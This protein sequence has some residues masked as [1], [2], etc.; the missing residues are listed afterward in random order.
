MVDA[1][2]TTQMKLITVEGEARSGKGTATRAIVEVL[3]LAGHKVRVVDQGQKFRALAVCAI[4]SGVDTE[5]GT[6]LQQFLA[7]KDTLPRMLSLLD[8]LHGVSDAERDAVLYTQEIGTASSMVGAQAVSQQLAIDLL[9][10][11]V[12]KAIR[13][14]VE[15]LVIDG[16]AMSQ[17]A[18]HFEQTLPVTLAL[19]L[20]FRTWA[21]VAARR[22]TGIMTPEVELVEKE[23]ESLRIAAEEVTKRNE[24]DRNRAV[25][26]LIDPGNAVRIDL[27]RVQDGIPGDLM[28][29]VLAARQVL[30]DTSRSNVAQMTKPVIELVLA[31]IHKN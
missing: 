16:R 8:D 5:D 3:S 21:V 7:A 11:Q 17:K 30:I 12:E 27:T 2:E 4:R 26:P 9:T 23:R 18:E 20:H 24:S 28:I 13:D 25:Y 1:V 15:V 19:G 22:M 31:A 29:D 6:S 10:A 14:G